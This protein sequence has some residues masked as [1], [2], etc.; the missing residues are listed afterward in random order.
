MT[1]LICKTIYIQPLR[2][3]TAKDGKRV[4]QEKYITIINLC[5][6]NNIASQYIKQQN[7]VELKRNG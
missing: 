1:I 6:T 3:E 4:A 5:V 7:L 2:Q